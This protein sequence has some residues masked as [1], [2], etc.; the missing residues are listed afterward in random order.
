MTAAL[1]VPC[2]RE[3]EPPTAT[4]APDRSQPQLSAAAQRQLK[5]NLEHFSTMPML[6]A[7]D[8]VG[9]TQIRGKPLK[10]R[11]QGKHNGPKKKV[12]DV[13]I[14]ADPNADENEPTVAANPRKKRHLVVGS[15][16]YRRRSWRC[17]GR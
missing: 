6:L 15:L 12:T 5:A 8:H 2:E 1:L 7:A 10:P 13:P 11:N 9:M 17:S 14:N 16:A 4:S 3:A